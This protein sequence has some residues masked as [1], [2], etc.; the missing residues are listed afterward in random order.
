[1]QPLF[2]ISENIGTLESVAEG[3]QLFPV[4]VKLNVLRVLLIGAGSVVTKP[5][6]EKAI[7][8][9]NPARILKYKP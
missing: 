2:N 5:V 3:N 6:P 7:V 1:M 4:F 9:G 8:A